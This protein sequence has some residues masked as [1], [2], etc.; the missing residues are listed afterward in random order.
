MIK[1]LKADRP[2]EKF[3]TDITEFHINAG[4]ICLS[5]MIDL[6]DGCPIAREIGISPLDG[7]TSSMPKETNELIPG[8]AHPIIHSDRGTHY[9]T[10]NR[11]GLM[12]EYGHA[13]SM[14]REGCPPD[15]AACEGCFGMLKRE[16]FHNHDWSKA[17]I[18]EFTKALDDYL[19]WFKIKRIKERL[20][21]LSPN[22]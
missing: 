7:F 16:F 19:K 22:V 2:F 15:N 6:F 10:D 5:P 9:G 1:K 14:S 21:Y 17:T 12:G 8:D 13:R 4:K 20:G 18:E 11:I 3:V